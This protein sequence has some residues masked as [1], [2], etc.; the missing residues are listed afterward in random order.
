MGFGE[1]NHVWRFWWLK[2]WRE[3]RNELRKLRGLNV[4]NGSKTG[5]KLRWSFILTSKG[6]LERK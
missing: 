1:C 6:V 2:V 3:G 4:I 5:E